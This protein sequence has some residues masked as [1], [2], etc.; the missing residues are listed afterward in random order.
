MRGHIVDEVVGGGPAGLGRRSGFG[1][2]FSH[3][4]FDVFDAGSHRVEQL[5][6]PPDRGVEL[7]E[8]VVEERDRLLEPVGAIAHRR[9]RLAVGLGG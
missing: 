9:R 6:E 3:R 8:P 7:I 2:V 4:G 5:A 1:R